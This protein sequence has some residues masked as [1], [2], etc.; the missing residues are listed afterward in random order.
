MILEKI[1]ELK[2]RIFWRDEFCPECKCYT[3]TSNRSPCRFC[4]R[5][6]LAVQNF[7]NEDDWFAEYTNRIIEQL[8]G[9]N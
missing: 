4:K 1:R 8:I 6:D 5:G 3:S 7:R 9:I 2:K